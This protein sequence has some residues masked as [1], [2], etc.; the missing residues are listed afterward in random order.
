MTFNQ[1]NL[2]NTIAGTTPQGVNDFSG[3]VN[4]RIAKAILDEYQDALYGAGYDNAMPCEEFLFSLKKTERN[5]YTTLISATEQ[6]STMLISRAWG[7][8][9]DVA[10]SLIDLAERWRIEYL[11]MAEGE[12]VMSLLHKT[13]SLL[14]MTRDYNDER[15]KSMTNEEF[16][17]SGREMMEV[18]SMLWMYAIELRKR[19][20]AVTDNFYSF[21]GSK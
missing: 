8:S 15:L 20:I 12:T 9:R 4:V 10:G 2:I 19:V 5:S 11:E 13:R 1:F 6:F 17:A 7:V 3:S 14:D 21:G 18:T 16:L